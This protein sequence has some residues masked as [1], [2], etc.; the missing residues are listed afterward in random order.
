MAVVGIGSLL[1]G[2][3][4][5]GSGSDRTDDRDGDRDGPRSSETTGVD[6]LTQ[7][8]AVAKL[9]MSPAT[10]LEVEERVTYPVERSGREF[11]TSVIE[12]G[13]V[14][15]ETVPDKPFP[16]DWPFVLDGAVYKLA[17]EVTE[18][19]PATEFRFTFGEEVNEDT[20]AESIEY[21][22]L[23]GVDRSVLRRIGF[24]EGPPAPG[25]VS[26]LWREG[27]IADSVL[28]PEPEYPVIVYDDGT[29]VRILVD[30]GNEVDLKTYV[31]RA[32]QV[33]ESAVAYGREFRRDHEVE[34]GDLPGEEAAIDSEDGY[35]VE[36]GD[37]P[38][39]FETLADRVPPERKV[40]RVYSDLD[41][42][43][44]FTSGLYLVDY[45]DEVYWTSIR[46]DAE[47]RS[48]PDDGSE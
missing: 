1:A 47:D 21:D 19:V 34:L 38:A 35:R 42:R 20:D 15:V 18:T 7:D 46:I 39:A 29:R 31:Y 32:V 10:D 23:P 8:P 2:C 27:E 6:T 3:V 26:T 48:P 45:E 13:P 12:D 9:E 4:A 17:A 36:D 24:E 22:A 25:G 33:H 44:S 40:S 41:W 16:P 37:P 5:G 43:T 30:R 28:V 14:T 11:P